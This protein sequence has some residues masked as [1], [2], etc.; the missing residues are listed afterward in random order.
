MFGSGGT[1][2]EISPT[3]TVWSYLVLGAE[4]L[5]KISDYSSTCSKMP[6]QLKPIKQMM[7]ESDEQVQREIEE[8]TGTCPC[9]VN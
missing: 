5:F 3:M 8:R 4:Q 1:N 2:F 6:I 9:M 7:L